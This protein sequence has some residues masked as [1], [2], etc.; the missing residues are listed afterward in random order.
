MTVG[1]DRRSTTLIGAHRRFARAF[2]RCLGRRCPH[3]RQPGIRHRSRAT[4]APSA[5]PATRPRR[6]GPVQSPATATRC[7]TATAGDRCGPRRNG[8]SAHAVATPSGPARRIRHPV[9]H[10]RGPRRRHRGRRDRPVHRASGGDRRGRSRTYRTG[11]HR[12]DRGNHCPRPGRP[13]RGDRHHARSAR[14]V[15]L[16]EVVAP[17][18]RRRRPD[19]ARYSRRDRCLGTAVGRPTNAVG[20][21]HVARHR[22]PESLAPTRVATAIAVGESPCRSPGDCPLRRSRECTGVV[23]DADHR[24]AR[25][26]LAAPLAHGRCRHRRGVPGARRA[27]RGRRGR[28]GTRPARR[29]GTARARRRA[30]TSNAAPFVAAL[31]G[32][33]DVRRPPSTLGRPRH[34]P[35]GGAI[36]CRRLGRTRP[37]IPRHPDRSIRP[38]GSRPGGGHDRR[39]RLHPARSLSD[40]APRPQR[41]CIIGTRRLPP[42]GRWGRAR[43]P[44]TQS[45]PAD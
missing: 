7:A 36:R 35:D 18:P 33:P 14:R 11:S 24:I 17:P 41:G 12:P 40:A 16:G 23:H 27:G 1:G 32:R 13:R 9:R 28:T 42:H 29:H 2:E 44:G 19:G 4:S 34:R 31:S 10:T 21:P 43:A 37:D 30:R 39:H 15:G 22:R 25:S 26:T 20:S 5:A 45:I 8:G 3:R 6:H 38:S